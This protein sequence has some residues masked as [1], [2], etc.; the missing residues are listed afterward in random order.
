M[1]GTLKAYE[2]PCFLLVEPTGD[3]PRGRE[4]GLYYEDTR[5]LSAQSLRLNG[6]QAVFLS[7]FADPASVLTH[8]LASPAL[9]DISHGA[10]LIRRSHAVSRGMH[11]D[12]DITSYAP[13]RISFELCLEYDADFADIFEIKR[14]AELAETRDSPPPRVT[15]LGA[16]VLGLARAEGGWQRRTEIRFSQRPRLEGAR[17]FFDVSIEPGETFHLCQDVYTIAASDF[18][19]PRRTCTSLLIESLETPDVRADIPSQVP[20][21]SSDFTPFDRGFA[22]AVEDLYTLR[23]RHLEGSDEVFYLAAGAPWFMALFGRDSLIASI[24]TI[25]FLPNLARGVLRSLAHLQGRIDD[26][27]VE[28]EPGKILH[29]YRPPNLLG[30]R[31]FVPRFPYYGSVDSTLLFIRLLSELFIRT[32]DLEFLRELEPHLIGAVGWVERKLRERPDGLIA[33]ERSTSYGLSNQGWKDSGDAIRFRKGAIAEA[34]IALVEVQGYAVDALRR[35]ARLYRLLG[36]SDIYANELEDKASKLESAIDDVFFMEDRQS[37]ALALDGR[38]RKVDALTSNP[39]H[40]LWSGAA[41]DSRATPLA[42]GLLKEELFSGFGLR[43]MGNHE[44]AYNP[45]S[46]HNGSVWPHDTSLAIAGLARYGFREEAAELGSGLL[47]ALAHYPDRRLPE[48]FAGLSS[49]ESPRPV[50]YATSNSPQAWAA[51]AVVLLAQVA[52]GL[53]IDVPG[54]RIELSP[55]LPKQVE[56]MRIRGIEIDGSSVDIEIR[57]EGSAIVGEVHHAPEG[58]AV[59]LP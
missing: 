38:G 14:C 30:T 8:Y 53:T 32:G 23:M 10:L 6:R 22:Q 26:P 40:L 39:A 5:F 21:L 59:V 52:L 4:L 7:A 41:R 45:I 28:E 15:A 35:A 17:A 36:R 50:E 27:E 3:M 44:G 24:Q 58:Y 19:P 31:R 9:V 37:Y 54:R 20:H 18:M 47:T 11:V 42:R 2:G 29:E 34:P 13:S 51:G 46:Y 12:I 56:R 33:Y 49:S 1:R 57:R 48:L 55:A 25:A 43:T 16:S